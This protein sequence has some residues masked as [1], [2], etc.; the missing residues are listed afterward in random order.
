MIATSLLYVLQEKLI[1][2][3]T[4]L[5]KRHQYSFSVPFEEFFLEASDGAQLNA[6]HFKRP[7]PKGV[8]VYFHGNAGDLSRWG[9]IALFFVEQNYDVII[10]DYRTYGKST[11]NL[12]EEN[13]FSDAELFYKYALNRYPEKEI[14]VYGRSLGAAIATNVASKNEPKKLI[15]ETPFYNLHDVAK[16][17]FSFLPVKQLLKFEFASNAYI[18]K[19]KSPIVIFHGTQDEVVPYPSG[20]KLFGAISGEQKKFYTIQNGGHNDLVNFEAFRK[21]IDQELNQTD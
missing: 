17:R 10:M 15:L 7:D 20:R 21:G 18:K 2:L 12:T 19:V 4:K 9:E 5:D 3:P 13:L 11:G 14:I 16:N 8:I 6:L 1:F